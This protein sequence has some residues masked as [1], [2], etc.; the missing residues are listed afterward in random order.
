MFY[1]KTQVQYTKLGDHTLY[2]SFLNL[3]FPQN[4]LV[5]SGFIRCFLLAFAFTFAGLNVQF[6]WESAIICWL[7]NHTVKTNTAC[8]TPDALSDDY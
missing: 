2:W 7:V 4:P 5:S 1:Q 8:K 3:K 6:Q